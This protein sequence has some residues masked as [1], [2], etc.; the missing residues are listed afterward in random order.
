MSNPGIELEDRY[1]TQL[2]PDP[3]ETASGLFFS[4]GSFLSLSAF[5]VEVGQEGGLATPGV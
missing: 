1:A 3:C 5:A 2:S 4:Q